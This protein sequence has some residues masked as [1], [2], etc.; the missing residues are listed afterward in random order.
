MKLNVDCHYYFVTTI[1]LLAINGLYRV[2]FSGVACST[3][4]IVCF[5]IKV[6]KKYIKYKACQTLKAPLDIFLK[7][8]FLE[9]IY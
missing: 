4:I 5:K 6:A 1:L 2:I 8:I 9:D 3:I 7:V